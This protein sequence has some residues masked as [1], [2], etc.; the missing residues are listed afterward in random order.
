MSTDATVHIVFHS[1]L[2]MTRTATRVPIRFS[3]T[4][5]AA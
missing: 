3:K 1:G 2:C 5:T 4:W